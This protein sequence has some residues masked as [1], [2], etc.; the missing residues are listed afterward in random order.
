MNQQD[1]QGKWK[2]IKGEIHKAWGNLTGD[3][4]EATKGNLTSIAGLIQQKY[5]IAKEEASQKLSDIVNKFSAKAQETKDS[6]AHSANKTTED[7]K[8]NLRTNVH[9]DRDAKNK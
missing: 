1:I 3:E 7:A 9:N 5:G 8:Q 2:D 6:V 4:V